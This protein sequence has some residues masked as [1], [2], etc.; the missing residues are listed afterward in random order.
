MKK[1]QK[2]RQFSWNSPPPCTT[3]PSTRT[4]YRTV[5]DHLIFK[6]CR[7]EF[8]HWLTFTECDHRQWSSLISVC[9]WFGFGLCSSWIWVY[10]RFGFIFFVTSHDHHH[11]LSWNHEILLLALCICINFN[12]RLQYTRCLTHFVN[13]RL[14][15]LIRKFCARHNVGMLRAKLLNA[16]DLPTSFPSLMFW[17]FADIRGWMVWLGGQLRRCWENFWS[18]CCC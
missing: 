4:A 17:F 16:W 14:G 12:H 7:D 1:R 9:F 10:A 2:H 5:D 15:L 3:T 18:N 6:L 13:V 8:V 11:C